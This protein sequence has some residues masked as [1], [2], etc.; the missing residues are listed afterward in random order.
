MVQQPPRY[1][2]VVWLS[3]NR[4][5]LWQ[6]RRIYHQTLWQRRWNTAMATSYLQKVYAGCQCCPVC[7]WLALMLGVYTCGGATCRG[8]PNTAVWQTHFI[9]ARCG[10][11]A[12]YYVI[13]LHRVHSDTV[14][15][16]IGLWL[17][18]QLAFTWKSQIWYNF[19]YRHHIWYTCCLGA[20]A[21]HPVSDTSSA[22]TWPAM[23]FLTREP[24]L[25]SFMFTVV[26]NSFSHFLF[27]TWFAV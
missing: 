14:H 1:R 3:L 25:P 17:G 22:A 7:C 27:Q 15:L 19:C 16:S 2:V 11:I 4:E 23:K 8:E 13:Q 10:L 6:R 24:H 21:P 12:L 5:S 9:R 18:T 26:I 20:G